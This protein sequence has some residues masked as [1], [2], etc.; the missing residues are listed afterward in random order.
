MADRHW[1]RNHPERVREYSRREYERH[2]ARIKSRE[3]KRRVRLKGR[4]LAAYGGACA[5]CAETAT[6]F[7]CIDHVDGGGNEHRRYLGTAG[8][9][10]AFYQWLINR[11]FPSGFRVLCM[12]CNHALG[13]YGYCPHGAVPSQRVVN[14]AGKNGSQLPLDVLP[15]NNAERRP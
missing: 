7:L 8:R 13:H 15:T 10:N 1:K 6:E 2:R 14:A 4:I 11:D 12:N 5:C 3:K 9:G